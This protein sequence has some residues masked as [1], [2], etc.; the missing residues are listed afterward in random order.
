MGHL[1]LP[2]RIHGK[3]SSFNP[4]KMPNFILHPKIEVSL[5]GN[6]MK[7]Y[8]QAFMDNYTPFFDTYAFDGIK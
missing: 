8:V 6:P 7:K 4:P 2:Q 5:N 3:H 1:N